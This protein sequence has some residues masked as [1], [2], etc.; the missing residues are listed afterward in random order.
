MCVPVNDF[1]LRRS[2]IYVFQN[3]SMLANMAYTVKSDSAQDP[4]F[5]VTPPPTR[6]IQSNSTRLQC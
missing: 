5:C 4:S 3:E 1:D 6:Y 2:F